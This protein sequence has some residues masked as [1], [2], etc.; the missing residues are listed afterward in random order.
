MGHGTLGSVGLELLDHGVVDGEGLAG[1][2]N[3]AV[4]AEPGGGYESE[5]AERSVGNDLLGDAGHDELGDLAGTT[6]ADTGKLV[7]EGGV[8][9]TAQEGVD[10][11]IDADTR[12]LGKERL[13]FLVH[14]VDDELA[15]DGVAD[16]L[17][18]VGEA[19]EL[20]GVSHGGVATVKEAELDHLVLLDLVHV[21]ND[22]DT[23]LLERWAAI[24]ELVLENPLVE[25]LGDNGPGILNTEVLG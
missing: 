4:V 5:A 22:L 6:K 16:N 15:V 3:A 24:D 20:T 7:L 17:V 21:G 10:V 23:S 1:I 11:V 12:D 14:H 13:D 2:V 18:D 8:G 19:S 9:E 25:G